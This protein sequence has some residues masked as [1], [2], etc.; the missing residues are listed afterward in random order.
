MSAHIRCVVYKDRQGIF[1][2]HDAK[3]FRVFWFD[4]PQS[5][6]VVKAQRDAAYTM[7]YGSHRLFIYDGKTGDDFI[8]SADECLC[9][10]ER[11]KSKNE[12][13]VVC[14]KQVE[15]KGILNSK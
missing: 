13:C 3:I 12:M 4:K 10:E 11:F 15:L 8:G 6:A 7:A 5:W 14:A 2:K 9:N 1:V